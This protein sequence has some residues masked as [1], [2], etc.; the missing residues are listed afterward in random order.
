M[1]VK[2]AGEHI[3]R[4]KRWKVLRWE[5]LKRDGF[6]C[7]ACPSRFR[8]EVDHIKPIRDFPELA[9]SLENLQTL[10]ARCHGVKTRHEVHGPL[11]PE[12]EKWRELLLNT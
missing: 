3:Y 11:S 5:A 7:R 6:K 9:Y 1:G 12:R 8:L 2:R 10:C 4:T